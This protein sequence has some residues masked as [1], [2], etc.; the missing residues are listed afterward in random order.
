[1]NDLKFTTAEDYMN[2]TN[3]QIKELAIESGLL[4]Q[5]DKLSYEEQKFAELIIRECAEIATINAHQWQTPGTYVL[6]HFE[7]E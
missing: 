6:K 5:R 2:N 7:I 3:N 1:M 4:F